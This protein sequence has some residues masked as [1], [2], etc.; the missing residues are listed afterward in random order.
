M[1][2]DT[3]YSA[4]LARANQDPKSGHTQAGSS[5]SQSRSN[6]DPTTASNEAIP[7]SLKSISA[8]YVSDTDSGF[9]PVLLSYAADGLPSVEDFKK[10]LGAKGNENVE[11]LSLKQFDPRREYGDVISKVEEAGGKGKGVKV[12]RVEI[13]RTRAEYYVLTVGERK[14]VGVVTQAVES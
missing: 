10:A 7:A 11:E 3:S 8:T 14:L 5:T 13:D 2:D 9:K 1:A 6:Y 4:F 12:F